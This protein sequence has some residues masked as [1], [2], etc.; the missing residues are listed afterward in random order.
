[1][2]LLFMTVVIP[3]VAGGIFTELPWGGGGKRG[4]AEGRGLAEFLFRWIGGQMCLW[5]GFHII[6]VP[7]IL[8]GRSFGDVVKVYVVYMAALILLSLARQIRFLASLA[9]RDKG[10]GTDS[11]ISGKREKTGRKADK[12]AVVL[13]CCAGCLLLLQLA[14]ACFLAYEEGD[15][16]FYVA[17]S[18]ST[19]DADTMYQKHPYTGGPVELDARHALAPFPVW[20][21]LIARLTGI[22][23]ATT[24][25]VALPVILIVMAYGCIYLLGNRLC[26]GDARKLP[27]FLLMAECLVLFGGYSTYSVENFLLVRTAQGKAVLAAIVLPFLLLLL[28]LLLERQKEGVRVGAGSWFLLALTMVTGCLCSTLGSFLTCLFVGIAGLCGAVCLRR[29]KSLPLLAGCCIIPMGMVFLY[30]WMR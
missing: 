16:A 7:F 21:A 13:W 1:M 23:P 17:I 4:S 28:Y 29:W 3:V 20:V 15:D 9:R 14:A 26:G 11:R 2:I 19:V 18:T 22:H 10:M 8:R 25:Q 12:V 5:A 27:L 30:F 24:A 6:C